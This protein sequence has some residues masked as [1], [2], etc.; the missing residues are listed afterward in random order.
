MAMELDIIKTDTTWNDAAGSVNKNFSKIKLAIDQGVGSNVVVDTEMSDTSENAVQNKVIKAYADKHPQ[1]EVIEEVEAPDNIDDTIILDDAM[2]DTSENGVKNKVIKAYVDKADKALQEQYDGLAH[3]KDMFYWEDEGKTVIGTKYPLF[4]EQTLTAGGKKDGSSDS[5]QGGLD[6]EGL[7]EYLTANKYTTETWVNQQGFAKD[8][9]L[10]ALEERVGSLESNGGGSGDVNLEG[11]ATEQWVREQGYATEDRLS[12]EVS[13]LNEAIAN[14]AQVLDWFE[15]D[16]SEGMIRAKYGLYSDGEIS[17]GGV[18]QDGSSGDTTPDI[19][20]EGYATKE[21]VEQQGYA[22]TSSVDALAERVTDLENNG[23]GGG[24][25]AP[26]LTGYATEQWVKDQ[27][28]VTEEKVNDEIAKVGEDIAKVAED[29]AAANEK[30]DTVLTWFEFDETE[31]MIRAKYGLYSDGSLSAGGKDGETEGEGG[32]AAGATTLEEL[33]D[34]TISSPSN[35]QALVYDSAT[36]TWKNATVSTSSASITSDDVI[37]AL[38][39]TPM[40]E[41]D[42]TQETIESKLGISDWAMAS[43]KPGY[44]YSEIEGA[45][46]KLSELDNDLGLGKLASQDAISYE[47]IE[48]KPATLAEHGYIDAVYYGQSIGNTDYCNLGY[49]QIFKAAMI[50][51]GKIDAPAA[52]RL[53]ETDENAFINM[54]VRT[55]FG[56]TTITDRVATRNAMEEGDLIFS[57]LHIGDATLSWDEDAQMLKFDKGIYSVGAVTAGGKGTSYTYQFTDWDD[58]VEDEDGNLTDSK[59]EDYVLSARLGVELNE[60]LTAI[61]EGN[62]LKIDFDGLNKLIDTDASASDLAAIGLTSD[63]IER[64]LD[65]KY[66]KV[67]HNGTNRQVWDYTAYENGEDKFIFFRRGDGFNIHDGYSLEYNSSTKVWTIS[68]GEI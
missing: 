3:L 46:T 40:D 19:D 38:G 29:A 5:S 42:F 47:D 51:F 52:I 13:G 26:D 37:G 35:G 65:A 53:N 20:L 60:R 25:T 58:W 24:T 57:K 16:S 62:N 9:D 28:Y 1:Y 15:Y 31:Q 59:L 43:S 54:E 27:Q 32:T 33:T 67:I 30:V 21:W 34:V 14:V 45:P 22:S 48:D 23:T 4:S 36:Q 6:E 10:D 7:E 63:A 44:T 41:K 39:Y 49:S 8:T 17:A 64:L 12:E 66:V 68:M 61:E 55:Q 2:S 56:G 50:A 18:S 11:Y